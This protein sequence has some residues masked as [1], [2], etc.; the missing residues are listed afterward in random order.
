MPGSRRST[1]ERTQHVRTSQMTFSVPEPIERPSV[2]T[3][4]LPGDVILTGTPGGIGGAPA[5]ARSCL[6]Q[7]TRFRIGPCP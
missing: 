1:T 6:I 2:V 5:P 7:E 4:V 3:P